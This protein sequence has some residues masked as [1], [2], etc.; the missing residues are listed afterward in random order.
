MR[1][2]LLLCLVACTPTPVPLPA[3]VWKPGV[4]Y[5]TD[6]GPTA[7]GLL[8]RKGLV[9]A[10]SAYSHDACDGQ[11]RNGAGVYD[12]ACF[13]DF[14]RDVCAAK[15]DFVFLTDHGDSFV[16]NE[17]PDVLLHRPM[18]G[19]TLVTHGAGPTANRLSCPDADPVLVMAGT[20]TGTMPVGLERHLQDRGLY[21]GTDARSIDAAKQVG[22][23]VLVAHTEDW[24]LEQLST[25]PLDGFEM[26]NLHRASLQNLGT[27]AELVLEVDRADLS[28]LPH[29][30]AF[31]TSF[32]LDDQ[33]Y[34]S[35]WG[36]LFARGVRRVTTM[37]TDCHRNTFPQL[38]Q[39]GE[40]IDSYRRMMSMF[41]NHLLV[42]PEADSSFDDRSLK[43]ALRARRLYGTFDFLGV[44]TGFD[45]FA[46]EGDVVREMGDE[47]RLSAGVTFEVTA[48]R[49]RDLDAAAPQPTI[50]TRLLRAIEGG[51][52][53]VAKTTDATLRFSPT[54]PGAYRAEIR[55]VPAHLR[56]H[57]GKRLTFGRAERPWVMANAIWVVP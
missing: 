23:V 42:R 17:F 46:K 49:V 9:H 44:P 4:V 45:F 57:L 56:A 12:E 16:E 24:T 1:P 6:R 36:T 50:T 2:A 33:T 34:F 28:G 27:A 41:A 48:P 5:R 37:G 13:S 21:S 52:E 11:P 51:W 55:I 43:E 15:H 3:A 32:T 53:E 14:R 31:F 19:D 29:P 35:R 8:D 39:D 10:H 22:A 38:L 54:Q 18:L 25:M 47:A 26:F 20:E 30:D 7:R 40:R